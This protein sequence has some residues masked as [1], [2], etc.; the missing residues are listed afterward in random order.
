SSHGP[1][2]IVPAVPPRSSYGLTLTWC[3][4]VSSCPLGL[5]LCAL[6]IALSARGSSACEPTLT[7]CASVSCRNSRRSTCQE[8]KERHQH[9]SAG[10][11]NWFSLL[12]TPT[13]WTPVPA[14]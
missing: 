12:S 10:S 5:S 4:W 7:Q 11:P 8:L 1:L 3:A 13:L 14:D 2:P 9:V 6:P